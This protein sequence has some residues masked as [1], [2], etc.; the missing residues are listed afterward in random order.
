MINEKV[1]ENYLHERV[2]LEKQYEHLKRKFSNVSTMRMLSFMVGAGLFIVG[3]IDAVLWAGILGVIFLL[4]FA[5]FVG[6]HSR[7]VNETEY[8][9]NRIDVVER[10]IMRYSDEWRSF[11]DTGDEFLTKQDT[12]AQDIDLLGPNS[13]Y[14]MISV[15]HTIKGKKKLADTLKMTDVPMDKLLLRKEAVGELATN[16][17][18]PLEFECAGIGLEKK[19]NVPS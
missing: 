7:I 8:T 6:I 19:K 10:Y 16:I 18:F 14:Q 5:C 11:R 12:V 15:A 2:H 1:K 17:E 13:L 9:K 4:I 3:T